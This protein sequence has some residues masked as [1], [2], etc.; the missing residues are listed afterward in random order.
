MQG[1]AADVAAG[2]DG[3]ALLFLD[4][5]FQQGLLPCPPWLFEDSCYAIGSDHELQACTAE[6]GRDQGP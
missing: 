6:I 5:L 3:K 1:P 2:R 4:A